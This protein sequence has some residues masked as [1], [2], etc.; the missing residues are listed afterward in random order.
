MERVERI[1]FK[2]EVTTHG[3]ALQQIRQ[4]GDTVLVVRGRPRILVFKCPCGC[5]DTVTVNLDRRAGKAWTL[6]RKR[7]E[8][9]LYPSVWRDNGCESHFIVWNNRVVWLDTDWWIDEEGVSDL[10]LRVIELVP[11]D[12]SI[13]FRDLAD[14]IEEIPWTVLRACRHLARTGQV[15]EGKGESSGTFR[16]ILGKG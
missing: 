4:P 11:F 5:G 16:R 1:R 8:L 2:G 14:E 6:Y 7:G 3:E 13:H 9:S 15:I 10:A 12:T